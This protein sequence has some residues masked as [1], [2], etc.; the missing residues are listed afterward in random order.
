M[1]QRKFMSRRTF[2]CTNCNGVF[3]FHP[4]DWPKPDICDACVGNLE[5]KKIMDDS[6]KLIAETMQRPEN[7]E[8]FKAM[9]R[10]DQELLVNHAWHDGILS[11]K[12]SRKKD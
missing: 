2:T 9:S 4:H 11:W 5:E 10:E 7:V 12:F 3:K 8:K 6:I 1:G